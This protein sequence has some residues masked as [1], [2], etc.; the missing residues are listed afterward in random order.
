MGWAHP[1]LRFASKRRQIRAIVMPEL[2]RPKMLTASRQ[3]AI[4]A[5]RNTCVRARRKCS[6][7]HSTTQPLGLPP[8]FQDFGTPGHNDGQDFARLPLP[9][10]IRQPADFCSWPIHR[11][12]DIYEK[13]YPANCDGNRL[14]RG[15]LLRAH[16]GV[17]HAS[18]PRPAGACLRSGSKSSPV[19]FGKEAMGSQPCGRGSSFRALRWPRR[20][21]R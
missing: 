10:K 21:Y 13:G 16:G 14:P 3:R 8:K 1:A 11:R 20:S 4:H 6:A 5:C 7:H 12:P 17:R 2:E 15:E 19:R 9:R 18:R